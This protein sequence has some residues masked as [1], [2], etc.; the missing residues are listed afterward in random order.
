MEYFRIGEREYREGIGSMPEAIDA[1]T[2]YV[3]NEKSYSEAL[4]VLERTV[5]VNRTGRLRNEK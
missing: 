5:D 3:T 2:A 4:A 1:Q